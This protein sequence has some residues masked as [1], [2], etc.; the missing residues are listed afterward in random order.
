MGLHIDDPNRTDY[1]KDLEALDRHRWKLY[2]KLF[3]RSAEEIESLSP[4][5]AVKVQSILKHLKGKGWL[6]VVFHGDRT[7]EEQE[8]KVKAGYSKTMNSFHVEG[9]SFSRNRNGVH[10]ELKGEAA[11]IV[12]ARYL[13]N[14]AAADRDFQFW[15]DLGAITNTLGLTWGGDWKSFPDVAHVEMKRQ[16]FFQDIRDLKVNRTA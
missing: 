5:F 3:A 1:K 10:W 6:P 15:K 12:D 13:W 9:T 14:G 4:I 8:E 16:E 11:D 2:G 7:R